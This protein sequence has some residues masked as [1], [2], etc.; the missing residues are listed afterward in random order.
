L[1]VKVSNSTGIKKRG[2]QLLI[3][4]GFLILG[5]C[6]VSK[7]LQPGEYLVE[8][9]QVVNYKETNIQKE[10]LEAFF[11]Q[12]PNRKLFRRIQFF[13]W[14]YTRFDPKKIE[15]RRITRNMRYDRKNAEKV[16]RIEK[17]NIERAKKGRRPKVPRLKDKE[18]ATFLESMRDIGERPVILDSIL[19]A[20]TR[21]QLTSFLFTKGY[22]NNRV[23]DTVIVNR[24]KK[25]AQV[26]FILEPGIPYHV[27]KIIYDIED[28]G[29][30]K[31]VLADSA[32]TVLHKG[33]Q[34]DGGKLQQER[35]RITDLARNHGY[36]YFENAYTSF[37]LDSALGN[38]TVNVFLRVTRQAKAFSQ[39][40]DSL[41]YS[42]HIRYTINQVYVIT[43]PVIGN[44]REARFTDTLKGL[45]RGIVFLLN[46]P[47][48][49]RAQL[50]LNNIDIY[51][52]QYFR[53]DTAQQTYKQ[54]LG[55]G[56][57][58][59]VIVQFIPTPGY[60]DRLDCYIIGSPL[61]RQSLSAETEGTNTSGNLGIAGS[62]NYQNRNSFKGG[63]TAELRLQGSIAA[64]SQ[65]RASEDDQTGIGQLPATFN[66]IQFGPE[67][68]FSVPRAFFPFSLLPF[69]RDMSP[70]TYIKTSLNYQ[71]RPEF[72]RVITSVDYGFSFKTNNNTLRHDII[73][74]EVYFVRA[75]LSSKFQQTLS[76][77]NDA[78]LVNSF[79][80][81]VTT[82]S[83][84]TVTYFT[85]ENTNTS[86][87]TVHY[88][89]WSLQSS[90]SILR[91]LF[92]AT[93]REKDSI[94]R[95]LIYKIPFAHFLR[96]EIDYRIYIPVR[97]RSRM[98]Y[99]VAGGIGKPL[100]NLNVLPYEQ[101]FFS[102]GPNSVRA[103]R[104]R[105]LGPGG[106]DPRVSDARYDKIGDILL[107]GNVEYRF[108]IIKA[109]NGALFADAGNIWRLQPDASKPGGE[110]ALHSFA[111]EIA[112]G[113]GFGI[114]WDLNFFVLRLDLAVPLKDPKYPEG[115]RLTFNKQPWKEVVANFGIG[116][117]F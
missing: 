63:E 111:D 4:C 84:Y 49:Y 107:E 67:F 102:G 106:Y 6:N 73:P 99:R 70:R 58:K 29:I 114:R 10:D 81:H 40:N 80:D 2:L 8:N 104:A 42:D 85:K 79:Q 20:Q 56:I 97:K 98:V 83:R 50:L 52:G 39:E 61:I 66:T 26:R 93:G 19:I 100:V 116:Y 109:F 23:T 86:R 65:L 105:T 90:G 17:K 3:F 18:S 41:V 46:S 36:Y 115:D 25:T 11:R 62:L 47:L 96:T 45:S 15:Q 5:S 88:I 21:M 92:E 31:L 78:F 22:Y 69:R 34:Y 76:D 57:F 103:W 37:G 48:K 44:V 33:M 110:F 55:L 7:R 71:A 74:A 30:K 28:E 53:K 87:K 59:N 9:V 75:N 89:R 60:R 91:K 43:E 1:L 64:Q 24:R 35:E 77:L 95:Y 32:H 51:P 82:L 94:G 101:S 113:G 13:A 72:N 54:L 117:P 108:H 27:N 68:S 12:K 38:R 14:W 16:R 112:I